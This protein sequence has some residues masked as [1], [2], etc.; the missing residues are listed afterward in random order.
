M[1]YDMHIRCTAILQLLGKGLTVRLQG[2]RVPDSVLNFSLKRLKMNTDKFSTKKN[3]WNK[4]IRSF[5]QAER[6]E[7]IISIRVRIANEKL[8]CSNIQPKN[9]SF[10]MEDSTR[11]ITRKNLVASWTVSRIF[12]AISAQ[13]AR[14]YGGS[15]S[16]GSRGHLLDV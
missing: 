10:E 4:S 14:R 1:T 15:R 8:T 2:S 12:P 9:N 13:F 6:R 16:I 11:N 5:D 3:S 7:I